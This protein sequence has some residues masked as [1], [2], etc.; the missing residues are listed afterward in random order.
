MNER[1]VAVSFSLWVCGDEVNRDVFNRVALNQSVKRVS[2]DHSDTAIVTE[3]DELWVCGYNET[4]NVFTRVEVP[5]A[6]SQV[7]A[8][9]FGSA[10]ITASGRVWGCGS[11][12]DNQLGLGSAAVLIVSVRLHRLNNFTVVKLRHNYNRSQRRS[13]NPA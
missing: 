2:A 5:F 6:V 4:R 10:L 1:R 8:G 13:F 12:E 11:N 3:N 9:N 7:T